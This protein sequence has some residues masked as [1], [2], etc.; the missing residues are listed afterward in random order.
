MSYTRAETCGSTNVSISGPENAKIDTPPRPFRPSCLVFT[1]SVEPPSSNF[2]FVGSSSS[3]GKREVRIVITTTAPVLQRKRHC[4]CYNR[5]S[6]C[7]QKETAITT[8]AQVL[9]R[10]GNCNYQDRSSFAGREKLQLLQ[11]LQYCSERNCDDCG[12]SR[13]FAER[14]NLQLLRPLQYCKSVLPRVLLTRGEYT[15]IREFGA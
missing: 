10:E 6:T 1:I 5:S 15:T 11:P 2:R 3:I 12:P 4:N 13:N 7:K 8:T 14:E 9:H